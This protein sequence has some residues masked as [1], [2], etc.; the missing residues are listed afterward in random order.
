MIKN[1]GLFS[2]VLKV[3]KNVIFFMTSGLVHFAIP[4]A[5]N[6]NGQKKKE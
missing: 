4:G 2:Q 3:T 6:L 5:K 1:F